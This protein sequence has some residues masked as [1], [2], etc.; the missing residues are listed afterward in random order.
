MISFF[1]LCLG[2]FFGW[3]ARKHY[4]AIRKKLGLPIPDVPK[5]KPT[6]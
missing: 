1:F 6:K 3:H 5:K 4:R 2:C